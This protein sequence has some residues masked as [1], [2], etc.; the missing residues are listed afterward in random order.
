MQGIKSGTMVL[1]G[2]VA[3]DRGR[4]SNYIYGTAKG[5]VSIFAQGLRN[6]LYKYGVNVI[7]VKPGLTDTPMTDG[8]NKD[9]ILWSSPDKVAQDIVRAIRKNKSIVYS[10]S[11]WRFIMFVIRN[12][13]EIIF[14]KLS[15]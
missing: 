7:T 11:Y 3:G 9:G 8:M 12:I 15:L 1:I 10:P 2:S 6:R 13:P 5:C 4:Q 14:K